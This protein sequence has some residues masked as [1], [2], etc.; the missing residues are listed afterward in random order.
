MC[1]MQEHCAAA[2]IAA[3]ADSSLVTGAWQLTDWLRALPGISRLTPIYTSPDPPKPTA[4]QVLKVTAT[5]AY[6]VN[7]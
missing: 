2:A 1:G 7:C 4:L 5:G 3:T 6:Q